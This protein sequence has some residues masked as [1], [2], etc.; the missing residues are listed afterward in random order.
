MN[1]WLVKQE[2]S[3]YPFS[4]FL[5]EKKVVWDGVRNYQARNFLRGMRKGD[6]VLYYHSVDERAV[7]GTAKVSRTAFPDPTAPQGEDWTSVEL[8]VD[9]PLKNPV[10]LDQL[11][12]DPR[13]RDLLLLRQSRLSVMPVSPKL[14]QA[15]LKM[16]G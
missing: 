16:G 15:L 13:F 9:R 8:T 1:T 5:K 6:R 3:T 14:F 12:A 2:P 4:R 7:V 10:T 11:K